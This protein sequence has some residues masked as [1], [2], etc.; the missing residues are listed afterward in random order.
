MIKET[1][2]A[3]NPSASTIT[4]DG[5][6][7]QVKVLKDMCQEPEISIQPSTKEHKK[8]DR[9]FRRMRHDLSRLGRK[10]LSTTK[11]LSEL[12]NHLDLYTDY[13]NV[14]RAA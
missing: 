5:Y 12:Q 10:T 14:K 8:I 13:H 3:L 2:K 9:V 7:P 6:F 1:K 4:C 11:S